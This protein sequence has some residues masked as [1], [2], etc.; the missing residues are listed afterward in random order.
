MPAAGYPLATHPPLYLSACLCAP[1]CRAKAERA[2][3]KAALE[4]AKAE[5]RERERLQRLEKERQRQVHISPLACA[6]QRCRPGVLPGCPA[7]WLARCGV[8]WQ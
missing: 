3:R 7:L 8:H 6:G 5:R 4:A 1:S 2:E